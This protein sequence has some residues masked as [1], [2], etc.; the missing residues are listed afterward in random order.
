MGL[1]SFQPLLSGDFR[2]RGIF[3]PPSEPSFHFL[4]DSPSNSVY[5]GKT[6]ISSLPYFW[7]PKKLA[8]PHIAIVGISGSGK[9]YLVK[10]LLT[11]ASIVW[12][13]NAIILDWSGEYAPWVAQAGGKII[14]FSA[15]ESLNLLDAPSDVSSRTTQIMGALEI[16][17]DISHFSSQKRLSEQALERAYGKNKR[18]IPTMQDVLDA[19]K[20]AKRT[21]NSKKLNEDIDSC[22]YRFEKLCQKGKNCFFGNSTIHINE[23]ISSGLVCIDLHSLPSEQTRSL[24][25][26]T[27]LQFILEIMRLQEAQRDELKLLV[28]LDEAWKV[29]QDE[30]SIAV[31]IVREGRKYGFSL[32]VASQNPTDISKTILSNAGTIFVLRLLLQEYKDYVK[33]SLGYSEEIAQEISNFTTGSAAIHIIPREKPSSH[34]TFII[35]KIDGE[36]PLAV[37]KIRGDSLKFEFEKEDLKRKL[38]SFGLDD[39]Q[40]AEIVQKF[41]ASQNTLSAEELV[42]LLE[43]YGFSRSRIISLLRELGAGEE[44]LISLFSSLQKSRTR[45][46]LGKPA[47]LVIEND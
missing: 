4:C 38:L 10:T 16:L 27:I 1:L 13:T 2:A 41:A 47:T 21:G 3:F 14:D 39:A 36:E 23:L 5:I 37:L 9:S 11:R 25:C 28:V 26:L 34:P 7:N 29:A 31:Q 20:S 42:L 19:L 22:I 43:K 45:A 8:N 24:A 35:P 18:K 32:I 15:G 46:N 12:N 30:K 33:G 44:S 17:T 40:T 6:R